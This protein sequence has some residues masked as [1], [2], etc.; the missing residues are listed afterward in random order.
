LRKKGP[1]EFSKPTDGK[2]EIRKKKTPER[3][4]N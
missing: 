2:T 3:N 1:S 4:C